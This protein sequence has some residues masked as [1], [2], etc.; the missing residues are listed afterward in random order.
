MVEFSNTKIAYKY[1][2]ELPNK[3]IVRK[4]FIGEVKRT[5]SFYLECE[6]KKRVHRGRLREDKRARDSTLGIYIVSPLL[7][8]FHFVKA[9]SFMSKMIMKW[10]KKWYYICDY[11]KSLKD[12]F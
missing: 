11:K 5:E 10:R 2:V 8:Y 12:H 7:F 4:E 1:H 3:K 6:K 9:L